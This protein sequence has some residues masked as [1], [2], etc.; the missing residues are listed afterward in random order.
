VESGPD[1]NRIPFKD[2][3]DNLITSR[4]QMV[5][6][7]GVFRTRDPPSLRPPNYLNQFVKNK[8]FAEKF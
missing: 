7:R 6:D 5:M 2:G 1:S 4:I 8:I 3:V